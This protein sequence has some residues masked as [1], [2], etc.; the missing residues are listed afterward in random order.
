[1]TLKKII[2]LSDFKNSFCNFLI[3]LGL[4]VT[5]FRHFQGIIRSC[6]FGKIGKNGQEKKSGILIDW[7]G[8][9]P[10]WGKISEVKC[11]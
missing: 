3:S 5:R 1:M 7:N 6:E 4:S 10:G 9:N 2:S 8:M 11:G